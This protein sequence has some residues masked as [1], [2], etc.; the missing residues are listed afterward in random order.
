MDD[1]HEI[2]FA[3]GYQPEAHERF[4][5]DEF[6]LPDWLQDEN[7]LSV[8]NLLPSINSYLFR[9]APDN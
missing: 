4:C 6:E 3:P 2:D 1:V 9:A 8:P 5:L 7:S